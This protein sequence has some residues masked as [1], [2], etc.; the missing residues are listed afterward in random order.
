[1]IFYPWRYGGKPPNILE[2]PAGKAS[3]SAHHG[4]KPRREIRDSLVD[5]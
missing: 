5:E 3:L 2:K 4:G 1:M